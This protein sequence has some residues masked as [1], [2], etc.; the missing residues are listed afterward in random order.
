MLQEFLR[1]AGYTTFEPGQ[2]DVRIFLAGL[3]QSALSLVG[4]IFFIVMLYGG[5][6][7]L[8]AGGNEEQVK[9]AHGMLKAGFIGFLVTLLSYAL[10]KYI[11]GKLGLWIM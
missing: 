8:T 1:E 9:K 10:T 5:F 3:V 2:G 11:I 6:Q 7:W 4:V